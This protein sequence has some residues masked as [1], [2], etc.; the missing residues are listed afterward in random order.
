[1]SHPGAAR[2]RLARSA[3]YMLLASVLFGFMGL[4]VKLASRTV[5]AFEIVFFRSLI[6]WVLVAAYMAGRGIPS[7]VHNH[8]MMMVR[9]VFGCASMICYFYAI[10]AIPLADAV[11][12][13]YTAPVFVTVM[14]VLVLHERVPASTWLAL[15]A[16][17]L[18]V[19][20][21]LKPDLQLQWGAVAGVSSSFLFAVALL[22]LKIMSD[23]D[24]A[25]AVVYHFQIF[26]TL[27][28]LPLL[29]WGFHWPNGREAL[30]LLGVAIP[31][32]VAQMLMTVAYQEG[33]ASTG[34]VISLTTAVVAAALGYLVLGER[35]DARALVGGTIVMASSLWL[36]T[37][38][39][40]AAA[41]PP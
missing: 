14:A 28:A 21:I 30:L 4:C 36:G 41:S 27:A 40:A 2:P 12:L 15:P 32:G 8:R 39:R 10:S 16:S 31:A 13:T 5:P 3:A 9:S 11:M 38:G 1:M 22:A 35:L 26:S 29:L 18:G 24:S 20:L 34:S 7:R 6:G 25:W 33:K 19:F 23:S 37:R 17:L